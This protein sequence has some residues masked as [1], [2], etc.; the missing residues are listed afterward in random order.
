MK[1]TVV[2]IVPVV[3]Y[4]LAFVRR[5]AAALLLLGLGGGAA[6]AE[7]GRTVYLP[8]TF[9]A[10]A[11]PLR[12]SACLQV[13]ERVYP[14]SAWWNDLAGDATAA[15][16]AFKAV[17]AAIKRR[18]RDALFN[19]SDPAQG[20]D[21]ARFEEQAGAFF[22]Q[23]A[24]LEMVAV[25]RAYEFDG[26]ALF[27]AKFRFKGRTFH[28]P[29]AFAYGADGSPGFLPYRTEQLTY[30][31]VSDWFDAPWGPGSTDAASYCTD[32]EV[33]RAGF[34]VALAAAP[35]AASKS[36]PPSYLL[37]SGASL[38]APGQ[39]AAARVKS[40]SAELKTSLASR[41]EDVLKYMTPEGGNRLRS[42]LTT[43]DESERRL[44]VSSI[45]DSRP[46]FV[47]DASPLMVV[48]TKSPAGAV[49]VMYFTTAAGD[50]L[51]WTNSSHI[52]L[53]DKVFKRGHVYDSA[54][55]ERPFAGSAVK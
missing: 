39:P 26:L 49:N 52:T 44:Y 43:A 4:A 19:L 20:R 38:D 34:R 18:D 9:R 31:L 3:G 17:V 41:P 27:F 22:E 24:A 30:F 48:Y 8:I 40:V 46:F 28:A 36:A 55:A 25:P 47:I 23:F 50:R 21:P 5:L 37:L 54:R 15:E 16:R 10:E 42:W 13:T 6:A 53:S 29:L 12:T 45:T 1:R 51:L 14:Q 33:K 7:G 32:E 2:G 35:P 11:G